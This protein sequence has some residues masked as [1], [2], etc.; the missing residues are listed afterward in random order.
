MM[1][2]ET[3]KALGAYYAAQ[4]REGYRQGVKRRLFLQTNDLP[5]ET[6]STN[7]YCGKTFR[8]LY[9]FM[10]GMRLDVSSLIV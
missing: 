10:H 5:L 2:P 9:G 6:M 1:R 4:Y 7:T 8:G 3:R